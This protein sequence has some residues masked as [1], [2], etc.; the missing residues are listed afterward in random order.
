MTAGQKAAATR[1][2]REAGSDPFIGASI[3]SIRAMTPSEIQSTGWEVGRWQRPV[4]LV[5]STGAI[6]F[7]SRDDEGNGP[8]SMWGRKP[9]GETVTFFVQEG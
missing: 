7:A 6:L 3:V 1:K 8:G 2:A 4:A 5:L 9:N